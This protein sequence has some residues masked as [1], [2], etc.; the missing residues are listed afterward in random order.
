[1]TARINKLGFTQSPV[2]G[3]QGSQSDSQE[4]I[5]IGEDATST[6]QSAVAFGPQTLASGESSVAIGQS[7]EVAEAFAFAFGDRDV[8]LDPNREI[9]PQDDAADLT[10]ANV[11]STANATSGDLV[12]YTFDVGGQTV[13]SIRAD[14]DGDGGVTS[15]RAV[16]PTNLTVDGQ[17]AAADTS[18]TG[19]VDVQDGADTTQYLL[20]ATTSPPTA[21]FGGN[22][23]SNVGDASIAS[24][25][26]DLVGRTE[27]VDNIDGNLYVTEAGAAD[28]TQN[29][30]D[31][32]IE[33]DTS[34][35]D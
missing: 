21:D 28:P 26:G 2:Q 30:G 8:L 20:D 32:W 1:M 14:A 13:L 19:V 23:I 11:Q 10:L 24:L 34:G 5:A 3:G 35:G 33:V 12:G 4:G 25:S 22:P 6:G 18:V 31:I 27:P 17:T 15:P 7:T 16:I 9:R 29:D